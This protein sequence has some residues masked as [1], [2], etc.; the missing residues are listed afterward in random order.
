VWGVARPL[1]AGATVQVEEWA[2]GAFRPVPGGTVPVGPRGYFRRTLRMGAAVREATL[3][4]LAA[5]GVDTLKIT[6]PWRA[7]APAPEARAR[8]AG[9]DPADPA[10]YEGWG[11][12]DQAVVGARRRGLEVF[13]GVAGPAPDWA[14]AGRSEPVGVLR[15]D[16]E[17]FGAF[18][19][20]VG[21]RWSGSYEGLPR[22]G[23]WSVWNEP[24]LPRF[25]LPQ[26]SSS[27][28]RTPVAPHVYRRLYLA[29]HAGLSA[30]GHGEDAIL[31]GELLPIGRN[32]TSSRSSLRPLEFLREMACVDARMRPFRGRAARARGC[33]GYRAL[34][35]LGVAHHP[36]TP[37]AGPRVRPRHPDDVTIGVLPRLVRALDRLGRARRLPRGME[38]WITE[39]GFQTDPP[40]DFGARLASVPRFMAQ[41]EWIAARSPRVGSWSQYPLVDDELTGEGVLRFGG[42]Q[43]GLRFRDGR[44][45]P[46]VYEAY[47]RP[48]WVRDLGRGRVSVFGGVRSGDRSSTP[49]SIEARLGRGPYRRVGSAPLG[50]RGYFSRTLR[51]SRAPSL[52]FRFRWGDETSRPVRA[53]RR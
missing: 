51:L 36:Y 18:V 11:P 4:E 14:T 8:P 50:P 53:A 20:A 5:L 26:R 3:D 24:N 37:P 7:L 39:F 35:G 49:V 27:R 19:R 10:Q 44:V 22:V 28:A 40:D 6:V 15:P 32:P 52:T 12:Y 21:R 46:A 45:K 31:M 16:P 17:E 1:E 48:L 43:S 13:V 30:T 41:S 29:A 9:F 2:A 42:F 47:R 34:P 25:L 33:T 38:V 23:L